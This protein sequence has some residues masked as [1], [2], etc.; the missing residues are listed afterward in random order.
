MISAIYTL[1][2]V[3]FAIKPSKQFQILLHFRNSLV[4]HLLCKAILFIYMKNILTQKMLLLAVLGV[5]HKA[6]CKLDKCSPSEPHIQ[7][8]FIL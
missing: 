2:L 4:A 1:A 7:Q 5:K 3:Y 8:H 6:L